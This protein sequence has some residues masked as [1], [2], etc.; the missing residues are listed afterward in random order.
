MIFFSITY[1]FIFVNEMKNKEG[2]MSMVVFIAH[3]RHFSEDGFVNAAMIFLSGYHS[4]YH[5]LPDDNP[6]FLA[7]FSIDFVYLSLYNKT[8]TIF[9]GGMMMKLYKRIVCFLMVMVMMMGMIP[10][11]IFADENEENQWNGKSAV[12]VG[13]S[14]TAGT[15]TT[16]I[17]YEY[18]KESLGLGSVTAM[19]V[20]GSCI[21]D[22]SDYGQKN[23]P[24]INRYLNIPSADLIVI[25]MGTNDYGHETPLGSIE[26]KQ[27]GT[28]CGALNTIVPALVAKHTSSKIVFVTSLHRYGFG[29]SK[30][31]GT[32]FT[33]DHIPNGVG[34]ALGDYVDAIK[35]VCAKNGV[36]VL[37]LHTECTLDPSD[38]EVRSEY[39]PDGIHPNADGH[40][41]IAEIIASHIRGYE[42]IE[43]DPINLTEMIHGNKFAPSHNQTCRASSRVNYYLKAGT[44]ITLKDPDVMQWSCAKT[45]G[46]ISSTNLGYFP[47]SQWTDK[48]TAVVVE[49]GWV[50]FVFK[51]RDETQSFDLSKPLTDYITIEVPHTHEYASEITV[52]TCTEQGYTTYTC[53][54]GDSYVDDYVDATGHHY[55]GLDCTVCVKSIQPIPKDSELCVTITPSNYWTISN[56]NTEKLACGPGL[57]A[58]GEGNFATV[59]LADDVN[60]VETEASTTIVCRLGLFN[61]DDPEYGRFYDIATAGQKL[62]DVIIGEK[63][64]Y[65][66]NLLALNDGKLLVLFNVRTTEGKY[67]YYCAVFDIVSNSIES[68]HPLTLDG[69]E[70]TP[71]NIAASY[72]AIANDTISNSGPTGS[73]VFTS[74]VIRHQGYYYGYCGGISTGFGGMLVRSED[75]INWE[76]VM[77]PE[78]ADDMNGVIECGFQF[79]EDTV[80]FCMRDISSGIYHCAYSLSTQEQL[81][82]TEK[83]NGLT[84]SKPT[85]FVHDNA[86]YVI[87]NK[88][89]GD[90]N[91]VGRRNTAQIYRVDPKN[92]ELTL[93][94]QVFCADGCA[95]HTVEE[96]DGTNYWCFHTDARRI[97]PYSQGRSNL[98]FLPI[99]TLVESGGED[100]VLDF[101]A[102]TN[103]YVR[104]C[105]TAKENIWQ[106]GASNMHYQIPLDIFASFDAVT[107]TANEAN[108]CYLAFFTNRMTEQTQIS[109]AQGWTEQLILE[110]GTTVTL[111]K[112]ED[113]QY[114]YVLATNAAGNNL[115]PT[116][117]VFHNHVYL[118][119]INAPTCTEQGYTTYTCACGDSYVDDYV[120]ALDHTEFIDKSIAPT[121]T[122]TGLTEGK[123]CSVC[124]E[125]LVKQE[126]VKANGHTE[127]IDKSIAPT[128]TETG[129]TEGKHCSVCGEILV[130]QEVVKANGHTEVIDKAIAPTCA[131]TGLTEGKHCSV[132]GEILV[133]QEIVK[134]NGHTEV[135][136][137]AIAPT[138][139]ETGLTE[140]KHCSVCG[141]ILVKQEIVK[142]TGHNFTNYVSDKNATIYA[143]GTKTAK[144]DH[145]DATDTVMDEGSKLAYIRGDVNGDETLNSADAIYLLRHTIMP[146]VYPLAQPADM[147][148]DGVVNSADAIY[149]L[150]HTIMPELY[151]LR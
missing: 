6:G 33:Y 113:A 129:L 105:I 39:M 32:K 35:T 87:V 133:K 80:Y 116:N 141:E 86:M 88:A 54:C 49:D 22:A 71:A 11:T 108:S 50:G 5:T 82:A 127:V 25:F 27:D 125:I 78:V 9:R 97:N 130:K 42:P 124:G 63:A 29:T 140:G 23:Q 139:T 10:I 134:A 67:I 145:C 104:G 26:D 150:R 151:P 101:A 149:L 45:N 112:P 57:V 131:E 94:K 58:Y 7:C 81:V 21:S 118:A 93:V 19:G 24:L 30:I 137:K 56:W 3:H 47:D 55:D 72:N 20:P 132:C 38:E 68:Y 70:W 84:T 60:S 120:D 4:D 79:L 14:I 77:A 110:P 121:C 2:R 115:I 65:E 1:I 75:G 64:P 51:Y 106:S 126:I 43:N 59:Y 143:D 62:G 69:K 12:F 34:A 114:M 74:K 76:S 144:C 148:G 135:I 85:A 96:F 146:M 15:G 95:Y 103:Y 48:E 18:L 123:H 111:E 147:N 98:A 73:M 13:D 37:D 138:C 53:A 100:G 136:D 36:S 92:C 142:A 89:T 122:E 83:L 66:P 31:L 16:K 102:F 41:L 46:E 8:K 99:P 17:Y 117:V 119:E 128:C 44:I 52:P 90:D 91:T 28:F 107:I 109:Y 61:I 40:E